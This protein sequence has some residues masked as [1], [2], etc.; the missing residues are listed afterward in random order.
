MKKEIFFIQIIF[1]R[2]LQRIFKSK[3]ISTPVT[4]SEF[5]VDPDEWKKLCS[6]NKGVRI[7]EGGKKLLQYD[8]DFYDNELMKFIT[9]EWQKAN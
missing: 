4:L 6:E 1:S 7:L 9:T 8:Y 5:E 2:F 3:K